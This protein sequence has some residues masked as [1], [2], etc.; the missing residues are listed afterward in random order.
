M[1]GAD[2]HR[3]AVELPA[4]QRG[5]DRLSEHGAVDVRGVADWVLVGQDRG[6]R[7][8]AQAGRRVAG[9]PGLGREGL[10]G[11][12]GRGER[13][14]GQLVRPALHDGALEEPARARR[15]QL[16]QRGQAARRL[17]E[18][19]HLA[20]IA[21]KGADVALHPAQRGLLVHQ[22]VVSGRAARAAGQR[23]VGQ[24][25][26]GAEPVIDGDHHDAVPDQAGR[27]VV[28][29][30][31]GAQRAAV[32]PDHHGQALCL[33]FGRAEHVQVQAVL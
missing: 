7:Q 4:G 28:V 27:V 8:A 29:A 16:G 9:A 31:A 1:V 17:A 32:H 20:G 10:S 25:T 11:C 33:V 5:L 30:L 6:D 14:L 2:D 24:E 12:F 18:Q 22:A 26:E 19:G 21:A 13:L 15:G 3:H 23:R